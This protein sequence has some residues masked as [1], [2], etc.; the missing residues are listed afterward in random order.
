MQSKHYKI[1]NCHNAIVWT[2]APSTVKKLYKQRLR[3]TYGFIKNTIDY[4]FMF[5]KREYGNLGIFILPIA[6][7]SIISGVYVAVTIVKNILSSIVDQIIIIKIQTIGF[8]FPDYFSF[9]D[10]GWFSI[11]TEFVAI[12]S[13]MAFLGTV[14]LILISRRMAEGK[15]HFGMDMVYYL[16][17][18]AFIAPLW[19]GKAVI[20]VL[21]SINTTWR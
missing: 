19:L 1:A 18:Y 17:L 10:I 12:A 15:V 4:R 3:W 16:S 9:G 8:T 21:F 20:N 6:S 7:L 14:T 2:V 11:N 13:L 5:L